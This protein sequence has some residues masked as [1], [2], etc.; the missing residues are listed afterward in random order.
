[1]GYCNKCSYCGA[2]LDPGEHCSCKE[3]AVEERSSVVKIVYQPQEKQNV[4]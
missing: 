1:M 2:N 4:G 3:D